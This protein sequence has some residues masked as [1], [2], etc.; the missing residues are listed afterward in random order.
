MLL[1]SVPR[2]DVTAFTDTAKYWAV[3]GIGHRVVDVNGV[4]VGKDSV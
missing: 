2:M 1:A 3:R 4:Q